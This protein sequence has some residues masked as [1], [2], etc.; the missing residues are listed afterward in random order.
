MDLVVAVV[1]ALP[2]VPRSAR[3]T[4][5]IMTT[6]A[7]ARRR[8]KRIRLAKP[9]AP[10]L[11]ALPRGWPMRILAS[12]RA[13]RRPSQRRG[14]RNNGLPLFLPRASGRPMRRRGANLAGLLKVPSLSASTPQPMDP[15][16]AVR[17]VNL[18]PCLHSSNRSSSSALFPAAT[19]DR[20]LPPLLPRRRPMV[21]SSKVRA[22]W[23]LHG[24]LLLRLRGPL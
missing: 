23:S 16:T 19:G 3:L 11:L 8:R 2:V 14:T 24:L 9:L 10:S 20:D 21:F 13:L 15:L 12:V 5:K 6:A 7:G 1:A 22:S 4:G 17:S 18:R